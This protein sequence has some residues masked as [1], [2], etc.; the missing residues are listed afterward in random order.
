MSEENQIAQVVN[1]LALAKS[2]PEGI[3]LPGTDLAV[4]VIA[5]K[6]EM[7]LDSDLWVL[8]LEGELIIDLPYGD[9]RILKV[10][11]SLQLNAGLTIS[12]QPLDEVI[13]L[14]SS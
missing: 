9:F 5:D 10:G 8:V 7:T 2:N 3:S 1:L 6:A 11:E 13:I 14:R 12:W 4:R